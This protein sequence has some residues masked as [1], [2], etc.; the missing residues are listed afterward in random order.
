M[1]I[2]NKIY[3]SPDNGKTIYERNLR[4]D[5][6]K[7][8]ET[9]NKSHITKVEQNSE[10]GDYFITI[11]EEALNSIGLV[12]GDEYSFIDRNDGTFEI[13]KVETKMTYDEAIAAG[14][15]MTDDGFWVK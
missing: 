8:L 13:R 10:T 1:K 4:S 7:L 3:E 11:P 12:E 15:T 6:R 14:W 5:E 2:R 9:S